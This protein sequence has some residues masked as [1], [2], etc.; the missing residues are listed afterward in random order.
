MNKSCLDPWTNL[1]VVQI[2]FPVRIYKVI[3]I[4]YVYNSFLNQDHTSTEICLVDD[5]LYLSLYMDLYI[6]V[7]VISIHFSWC[8]SG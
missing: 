7:S 5:I 3:Y 2:F 6:A 4:I 8:I 1:V